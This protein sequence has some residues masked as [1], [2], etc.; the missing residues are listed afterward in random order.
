MGR[1]IDAERVLVC[2]GRTFADKELLFRTLDELLG[3]RN[4]VIIHGGARGADSLAGMWALTRANNVVVCRADWRRH[5]PSAG[6]IRNRVMM[7]NERPQAVIAFPG[8]PGTADMVR[9]A[10]RAGVP[11]IE[12]AADGTR[13]GEH[14]GA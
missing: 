12:V 8:G 3:G 13:S 4:R 7:T 10:R 5:G 9:V 11:V 6:P 14:E 1:L 2:G